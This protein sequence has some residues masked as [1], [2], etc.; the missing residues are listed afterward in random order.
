MEE[1]RDMHKTL[2]EALEWQLNAKQEELKSIEQNMDVAKAR[3]TVL[4]EKK[5]GIL[6]EIQRLR[7]MLRE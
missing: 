1:G 7:E 5:A 2:K 6:V 4:E 3:I